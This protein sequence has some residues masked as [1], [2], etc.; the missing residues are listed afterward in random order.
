MIKSIENKVVSSLSETFLP[1]Y[2]NVDGRSIQ[3][4]MQLF[5][6]YA[7][8]IPFVNENKQHLGF[9]DEMYTEQTLFIWVDIL[10]MDID[11][12]D[13]RKK[14]ILEHWLL[15]G[16]SKALALL[17]DVL[18]TLRRLFTKA[19][20]VNAPWVVDEITAVMGDDLFENVNRLK[21]EL[22]KRKEGHEIMGLYS[23]HEWLF[24]ETHSNIYKSSTYKKD[25]DKKNLFLV[26]INNAINCLYVLKKRLSSQEFNKMLGN[27]KH[28]AHIGLLYGFLKSYKL[29]QN[30]FNQLPKRHL[31]YYYKT[32]LKLKPLSAQPDFT[33]LF[34]KLVPGLPFL[35]IKSEKL[36]EK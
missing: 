13:T 30:R 26:A 29:I 28:P 18:E 15:D 9:W 12:F 5:T 11:S 33:Y 10:C 32:I 27:G 36:S 20:N 7:K 6:E 22:V 1:D 14:T 16:E 34:V 3:E 23:R 17:D 25:L 19:K 4:I 21:S 35:K 24:N 31:D 2:V 8:Q